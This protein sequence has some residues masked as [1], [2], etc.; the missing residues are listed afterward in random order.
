MSLLLEPTAERVKEEKLYR[1]MGLTDEEFAMIEDILGRTPNWTETGLFSVMW[2]EHCSYKNSKVLLKKFPTEGERVLQGPG[3]GAGIIDIGDEQAVVFKVESHNHPSAI[4]PYQGAATGVGGILRDVFSMGARPISLLNSLRFGELTSPRVRYL[5]EEVV[6]G[7]A[8]YG[9]CMGVPTV[10]GEIQFDPCYE[11]NPLV[12]AMCVGLIDHKDIQKGQAK[13]VGNTVMYVGASTGRDGIHGATFASEELGEDSDE[14]RPAVQVG[15]PFMEKLL[16]EACLE[17]IQNDALVGIQ[18]MG[19]AGLTSSSAEMAS[20]AGSGIEM[21]LDLIPQREKGMTAYEMMLSESQ[22]RMLIVVKKGREQEIK[23]IFDRW[24]LLSAEVGHVT[25]DKRLRLLHKGEVVADLPVDAL[26]EEAPVYH[27]PSAVPAYYEKFQQQEEKTP[28]VEDYKETLLKLLAQPT[29]A[30]K[31]WVYDQYDYMVQ[32]NT[33]VEPGSDAAVVRIRGTRKALAMTTDCNSRYLYLD[34]EVGGQIAIA[35]AARNVVCSGGIPLG[36][37]DGLNY[38]SP[39]KPEIFWQLEKSTDGMS[40]ACRVLETPVIGGNVSLYNE[41]AGV[42]IYPTP[43]I[44]MVGLIE[45][46]DHITTQQFKKVGDIIYLVGETKPEFGGSELQKLIEGDISGKAPALDLQL[47]KR[48][49]K[50][51]L[52][53]IRSGLVSSAHDVAE[54][55]VSIALAECMTSGEVGASVTLAGETTAALFAESQTR[56]IVTVSSEKAEQF[57]QLVAATKIGEVTNTKTLQ[58]KND[59][60]RVILEASQDEIVTAWKGAIPCLLKSKA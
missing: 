50:Q 23:E 49:Q 16:L 3:E 7:I 27:K 6:A 18:D 46:I 45:D 54:G 51:L 25:D 42:A 48:L 10:G 8:G 4:E 17:L 56:F 59:E 44:G 20:K 31:E 14:K 32:T 34:P 19:A 29:I 40:E 9:N 47:E 39:D 55:G 21:N 12:N 30:S 1:E 22:E 57:E 2:S 36:L 15:D 24:G 38:G 13:G 58:I 60:Q 41:T 33:V 28:V 35:E 52:T 11:G 26:A 5:F 43:V 53:A 37:T